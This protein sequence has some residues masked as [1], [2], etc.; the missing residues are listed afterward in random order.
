VRL[1]KFHEEVSISHVPEIRHSRCG[2]C[3][4]GE[5]SNTDTYTSLATLPEDKQNNMDQTIRCLSAHTSDKP[6]LTRYSPSK[7]RSQASCNFPFLTYVF[8]PLRSPKGFLSLSRLHVL[9]TDVRDARPSFP[10]HVRPPCTRGITSRC[11]GVQGLDDQREQHLSQRENV[12][13]LARS[14]SWRSVC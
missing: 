12:E 13:L 7:L 10:L 6:L 4:G 9:S 11:L 14:Q 3:P 2:S 8:R 5:L 1:L